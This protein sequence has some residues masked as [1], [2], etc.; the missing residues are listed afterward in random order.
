[1]RSVKRGLSKNTKLI[2]DGKILATLAN[3]NFPRIFFALQ[4]ENWKEK[5]QHQFHREFFLQT[6]VTCWCNPVVFHQNVNSLV[7]WKRIPRALHNFHCE[8]I[9]SD[10]WQ[11]ALQTLGRTTPLCSSKRA[12]CVGI[13]NIMKI[14]FFFFVVVV[15]FC[16][17]IF[18]TV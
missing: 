4:E 13:L 17:L 8:A 14:M 1:M 2:W 12:N 18:K 16:S 6:S 10:I 5:Q 3:E 15:F 9:Y 7:N 11:R